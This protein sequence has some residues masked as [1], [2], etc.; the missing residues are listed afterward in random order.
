LSVGAAI[1]FKG[2]TLGGAVDIH[3]LDEL[4]WAFYKT[5]LKQLL[6]PDQQ[7]AFEPIFHYVEKSLERERSRL[8]F[9]QEKN[10][11]KILLRNE[12]MRL[13]STP[14][15]ENLRIGE[16]S[17]HLLLIL[18]SA[19]ESLAYGSISRERAKNHMINDLE[20]M[21]KWIKDI[22]PAH[23]SRRGRPKKIPISHSK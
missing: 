4:S 17:K 2:S 12:A 6:S 23:A 10:E 22:A 14:E 20:S 7:E 9:N 11:I 8:S 19:I 1:Y 15:Y 13:W 3:T 21:K 5:A 16:M 18:Q